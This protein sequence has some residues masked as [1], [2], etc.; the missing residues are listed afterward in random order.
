MS[1]I[2]EQFTCDNVVER[3]QQMEGELGVIVVLK[4]AHI[5]LSRLNQETSQVCKGG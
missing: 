2:L 5:E 1:F 4:P 3:P